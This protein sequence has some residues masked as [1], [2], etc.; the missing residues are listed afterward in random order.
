[1]GKKKY[2]ETESFKKLHSEW[3]ERLK[4]DEFD[5]TGL[6]NFEIETL[7]NETLVKPQIFKSE[8]VQSSG[9]LDYYEFCQQILREYNFF[10][11]SVDEH[12]RILE[13]ERKCESE[14]EDW[15]REN[16]LPQFPTWKIFKLHSE[17]HTDR[18]ISEYLKANGLRPYTHRRCGQIINEI[19]TNFLRMKT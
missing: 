17:G 8:K 3:N 16:C 7:D 19:K 15:L 2:Y 11:E 4:A 13:L 9:G 10:D 6:R 14:I 5:S 18:E 1:M 12:L